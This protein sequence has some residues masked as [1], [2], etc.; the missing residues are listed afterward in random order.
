MVLRLVIALSTAGEAGT[1]ARDA[2]LAERGRQLQGMLDRARERGEHP[3][4][5]LDILDHILALLYIRTLFGTG[6][7]TPGYVDT[8]VDRLLALH[9]RAL[10]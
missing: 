9:G 7:L 6:P 10:A 2:F 5:G 4:E 8:L 3:P 1:R